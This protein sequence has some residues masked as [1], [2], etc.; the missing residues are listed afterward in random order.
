MFTSIQCDHVASTSIRRHFRTCLLW[1]I[2][3]NPRV[4]YSVTYIFDN[5][6]SDP[7][8]PR[9]TGGNFSKFHIHTLKCLNI[10]TPKTINFP[11]ASNGKLMFLGV[12][13]SKH[14]IMGL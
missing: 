14:I 3:G 8:V 4:Y 5:S 12:P 13:I 6:I 10:G 1:V 2:V 9:M 7:G 11:F